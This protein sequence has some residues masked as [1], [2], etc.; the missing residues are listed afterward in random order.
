MDNDDGKPFYMLNLMEYRVQA[1]YR[2]PTQ[3]D[4][5][6]VEAISGREAGRRYEQMVVWQLLQRGSY[7]VLLSRKMANLL[8][9]GNG[10]DFFEDVVIV[11]YR[12]RRDMLAMLASPAFREGIPHKWASLRRTVVVPTRRVFLLDLKVIAPLLL[13]VILLFTRTLMTRY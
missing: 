1:E 2:D 3:P 9:A 4:G 7:P 10:T 11:R 5:M 13:I 12:S 8:N 6:R